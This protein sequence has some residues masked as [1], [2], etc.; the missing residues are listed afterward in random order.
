MIRSGC[1]RYIPS[2]DSKLERT[3]YGDDQRLSPGGGHSL[4]LIMSIRVCTGYVWFPGRFW[5]GVPFL[6]RICGPLACFL[7]CFANIFVDHHFVDFIKKRSAKYELDCNHGVLNGLFVVISFCLDIRSRLLQLSLTES[8][9]NR[10]FES[11]MGLRL[12][13]RAGH[14]HLKEKINSHHPSP[15]RPATPPP[16]S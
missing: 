15:T 5:E 2:L 12:K 6:R 4:Q 8:I 9:K 16:P 7:L 10:F 1:Q 14:P 3:R 13:T 11:E